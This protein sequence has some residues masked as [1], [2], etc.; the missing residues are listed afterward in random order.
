MLQTTFALKNSGNITK[1]DAPNKLD[2]F[3]DDLLNTPTDN[4]LAFCS[5]SENPTQK[6]LHD[7]FVKI[8]ERFPMLTVH[9]IRHKSTSKPT[10]S[11][12]FIKTK[13]LQST[14]ENFS[15]I[16]ADK[17]FIITKDSIF[18]L[19]HKE[20]VLI[21]KSLLKILWNNL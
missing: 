10:R 4:I 3:L 18:I 15:I 8:H 14:Q 5:K 11:M 2:I 9:E 17:V 1:L 7:T 21:I 13:T 19:N 20:T 6:I 16:A 12:S